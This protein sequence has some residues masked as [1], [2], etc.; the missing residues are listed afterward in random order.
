MRCSY[1][2][3]AGGAGGYDV[4]IPSDYKRSVSLYRGVTCWSC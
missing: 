1:G 4:I 2:K 3:L